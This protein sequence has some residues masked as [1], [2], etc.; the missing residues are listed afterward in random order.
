MWI[1]IKDSIAFGNR[2]AIAS[3]TGFS[4]VNETGRPAEDY[5]KIIDDDVT[6]N[7]IRELIVRLYPGAEEWV[8]FQC[9]FNNARQCFDVIVSHPSFDEVPLGQELPRI[10][11]P[12]VD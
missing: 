2:A 11:R 6:Y 12:A 1:N 8:L 7:V 10:E 9:Y 5:F 3:I 4:F